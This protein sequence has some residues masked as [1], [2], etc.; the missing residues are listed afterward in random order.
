MRFHQGC[1]TVKKSAALLL[2]ARSMLAA[3][4]LGAAAPALAASVQINGKY[5]QFT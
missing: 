3:F 5:S 1:V 2:M 4:V